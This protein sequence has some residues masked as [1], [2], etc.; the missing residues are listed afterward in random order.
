[1]RH[2]RFFAP[3]FLSAF[4]LAACSN[5]S[6][7]TTPLTLDGEWTLVVMETQGCTDLML[8][9]LTGG[10]RYQHFSVGQTAANVS[11]QFGGGGGNTCSLEATYRPDEFSGRFTATTPTRTV[12]FE[13]DGIARQSGGSRRVD[14]TMT[15]VSD[16]IEDCVGGGIRF[17]AYI[18]ET[19]EPGVTN[20]PP[21]ITMLQPDDGNT[22]DRGTQVSV[23]YRDGDPDSVAATSIYADRDG[24][25]GTT[26]DQI[27]IAGDRPEQDGVAQSVVWDTTGAPT[28]RYSIIGRT[29]D[30][31]FTAVDEAPGG[32]TIRLAGPPN[33]AFAQRV[34]SGIVQDLAACSQRDFIITGLHNAPATFGP[35]E[36]NETTFLNSGSFV[37]RYNNDG[38]LGWAVEVAATD[39]AGTQAVECF[40]DR[41][42]IVT[43]NF[44]GTLTIGSTMLTTDAFFDALVAR[45]NVDGSL[46]WARQD[47][48]A[49]GTRAIAQHVATYADGSC[50]VV[51]TYLGT[52]VFGEG[53]ANETTLAG[54]GDQD[55][56]VARYNADGSLVWARRAGGGDV[57]DVRN[58]A[59]FADGSLVMV[60]W[61]ISTST[62][63]APGES[64]QTVLSGPDTQK[65]FVAR[66]NADGT[67][68][69]ARQTSTASRTTAEAVESL[70]DGSSL[71]TGTYAGTI[72][73]GPGDANQTTVTAPPGFFGGLYVARY[74]PDGT[75]NWVTTA[76]GLDRNEPRAIVARA[77]DSFV[78]AG[79][80][81]QNLTFGAGGPNETTLTVDDQRDMFFAS[82]NADG[83]LQWARRDGGTRDEECWGVGLLP[84]GTIVGTG[85]F[86]GSV[87]FGAGD[88][89]ETMLDV[90]SNVDIWI[91]RFNANGR[92]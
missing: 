54:F 42:S 56:Y 57:E 27:L 83:S 73:F 11:A 41:S 38:S 65:L 4:L 78:L 62:T 59:T 85:N 60:G 5:N 40:A 72:T 35:G 3:L 79:S 63:F 49:P 76:D 50:A 74:N 7:G 16:T 9:A 90:G 43:G 36:V 26:G 34:A 53:E 6:P 23:Q 13:A 58:V 44:R 66:Y 20:R 91:A 64:N 87:T 86:R 31:E 17:C 14:G 51:G 15:V 30:G 29:T 45:F 61:R 47:G 19:R 21:T 71:V 2:R 46:A 68:A 37:A 70:A 12:V 48:G 82:F 81:N 88:P 80:F 28:G 92:Y 89:N 75:L 10:G 67:L 69:W 24:D 55:L 18:A 52:V 22:V 33:P 25:L 32:I 8:Q 1:M 77:D 84:D 39:V